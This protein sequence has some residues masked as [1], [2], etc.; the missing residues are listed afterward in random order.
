MRVLTRCFGLSV[1]LIISIIL[2]AQ[3]MVFNVRKD[4]LISCISTAMSSTQIIMQEQIEDQI[5][6]TQTKRKSINSNEQYLNEFASHF[7][8]LTTSNSVF[9]IKVFGIDY[10][11]GFLD[12]EIESQFKMFNGKT[13]TISSRKTSIVDVL[14]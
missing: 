14:M 1:I 8:K 12:I 7:Y 2:Y 6:N 11:K 5:L 13:K 3:M 4:E 9:K 10:T